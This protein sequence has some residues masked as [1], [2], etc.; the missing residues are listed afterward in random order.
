LNV[1]PQDK[2]A[3][4]PGLSSANKGLYTRMFFNSGL[5]NPNFS[6]TE[7]DILNIYAI[8]RNGNNVQSIAVQP[9][10]GERHVAERSFAINMGLGYRFNSNF[11]LET[12]AIYGLHSTLSKSNVIASP[13]HFSWEKPVTVAMTQEERLRP[14]MQYEITNAY[15]VRNTFEVLGIPLL[16]VLDIPMNKFELQLKGGF[17]ANILLSNRIADTK[18]LLI[19]EVI[20]PGVESPYHM[21]FMQA[22]TGAGLHYK[23]TDNYSV[24]FEAAMQFGISDMAKSTAMFRSH[25]NQLVIGFGMHYRLPSLR[26]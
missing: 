16:A 2:I 4:I 8:A 18:N 14:Q 6:L 11:S 26:F 10:L 15:E 7:S 1:L 17:Q 3:E 20:R 13:M 5:F 23:F 19:R 21:V 25:P 12:G 9:Q 22:V 24:G